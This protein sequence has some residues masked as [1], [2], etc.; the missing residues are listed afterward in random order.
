MKNFLSRVALFALAALVSCSS[1]TETSHRVQLVLSSDTL[2]PSTTFE[3][4]FDDAVAAPESVSQPAE[5][6]PLIIQPP[7]KGQFVWLSQRSGVFTPAEPTAL[8]MEYRLTLRRGLKDAGGKPLA[9]RL[10]RTL[11]TPSF[12][13]ETGW[14]GLNCSNAPATLEIKLN[15]NADVRAETARPY[16]EF[17]SRAG[18]RMS[19]HVVHGTAEDG[20][21]REAWVSSPPPATWRAQFA[22][23]VSG[24]S[25]ARDANESTN[26]VPNF[27]IVSP[28]Q[29]LPVGPGWKLVIAAGLPSAERALRLPSAHEVNLGDVIAFAPQSAETHNNVRDGRRIVLRFSKGLS[30]DIADTNLLDWIS[31]DPAPTNLTA[32]H[33]GQNTVELRGAFALHRSYAVGVRPGLESGDGMTLGRAWTNAVN[34]EP[35]PPRLY[36][37]A[38]TTEQ[39]AA[40]RREF[41]LLAVNTPSVRVRA[42]QLDRDTLIH[43][44]RGYKRYF[45]TYD[46]EYDFTE[47]Y[48]EVD[49]N[50]VAGRTIFSRTITTTN[51][52][53]NA[54][55]IPLH[56]DD[57]VGRRKSGAVFLVAEQ[58]PDERGQRVKQGTQAIVQLTDLGLAWKFT[59]DSATVHV[60]S[61]TTG[62]PVANATV[63]VL[64][65][66]SE[67]LAE[68][69]TDAQGIATLPLTTNAIWLM[70][71][72]GGDLHAARLREHPVYLYSFGVALDWSGARK[73]PCEAFLFTDRSVY[74]PGETVHFKALVRDRD[75]DRFDI[76]TGAKAVLLV[77]DP[78]D[79]KVFET[80]LT[81]SAF[82]SL[83]VSL[84]LPELVRGHYRLALRFGEREF[85]HHVQVADFQPNAFSVA[86]DTRP[87]YAAAETV[88]VPLRASYL[89]G[90]PV[91]RA[92]VAWSVE[93]SDEG[94]YPKGFEDFIFTTEW[95]DYQLGRNRSSFNDHGE[96][97]YSSKSN[98]VITPQIEFNP[99]AP[100]PRAVHLRA[101]VT[102]LNQQTITRGADF[103]AHSSDF[104]LGLRRFKEVPRAGEPLPVELIAARADGQPHTTPVTATLTLQRLDY[105]SVRVQGAGRSRGYRNELVVTNVATAEAL[106]MQLRKNLDKWDT[107]P[108]AVA[109]KLIPDQPGQY[110]LEARAKDA[111]GREVVTVTVFN[112]IGQGE[113]AWAWRN[114]VQ[115]D[116]VPD[117]TNYLAGETATVLV[118]SPFNGHALVTVEREKVLRSFV[119]E[120]SGNAP[121]IQVP[122]QDLDAPNVFVSVLLLRGSADS[123]KKFKM[124]EHRLGYCELKVT[125]PRNQLHVSVVP[126]AGDYR[127]AQTVSVTA[128][129]T[130]AIG[131]P[132]RDTEVTLYAVDEGILSL[133]GYDTPDPLSF[134][135]RP[136]PLAVRCALTLPSLFP[137]DPEQRNFH[138]KGY[139]IGGGGRDRIRKD[140]L[141]CAYWNAA[142]VT[143]AAGK[144]SATFNAP[145]SLTRYRVIAVA[146]TS[147]HQFGS[148]DSHFEVNKPLMVEPA[149]PRFAHVTDKLIARAVVHN[150]TADA[151]EIEVSLQLD[152]KANAPGNV[153]AHVF[154]KVLPV[155]AK[156]SSP[157][158]FPVEF[159][160]AGSSKWTWRAR[161]AES[162]DAVRPIVNSSS[163]RRYTDAVESTILVEYLAPM[164]REI[165]LDHTEA[166]ETNLLTAANPQLLEGRGNVAVS[167]CNSRLGELGEALRYLLHYPYGCVEQ[168]SSSLLPWITLRN[169][170]TLTPEFKKPPEE[171][172]KAIRAGVQRLLSMQT[173]SGGLS[174]WPGGREPM[175]WGSAYGGL[176]LTLARR[177]GQSVTPAKFDRLMKYLSA[178]LRGASAE[179]LDSLDSSA[180]CLALYTLALAGKAEPAYHELLF[181][182]RARLSTDNR[183]LL[184]LAIAENGGSAAMAAELLSSRTNTPRVDTDW[185]GCDS[186]DLALQLLAWTHVRPTD[187]KV[188]V[189][190]TELTHS[191]IHGHWYTTQGNAWAL[192]ALK[193]YAER[194]EGKTIATEG[195][196]TWA[197]QSRP[198]SLPAK[199]E[200][201][202]TAFPIAREAAAAPLTLA[203]PERHRLYTQ[204]TLEARPTVARQPRQ[205]RGFSIVRAYHRV[206]DDGKLQSTDTLHVGDRVLVTL[207]VDV[208]QPAHYLA[209]D[210]ALPAVL[211]PLNPEFKSQETSRAVAASSLPY[212]NWH[213]DHRE[214]RSDRAL[215]FSDH[216][217]LAGR[218]EIRYLTRVRAAGT[219][220]AP[221]AKVE[222][223]YH[224]DRFGLSETM[225]LT[226]LPLE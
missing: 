175:F 99:A 83:N 215:F 197:S 52:T 195:R 21:G 30:S 194:V 40:G 177:D 150:Q 10:R 171:F 218:Y 65:D 118:K 201:F 32:R 196:L 74:R 4:R 131:Q 86:L 112:V 45:K 24:L 206:D 108:G 184:A 3:L 20:F 58:E 6:G 101:E 35:L 14:I 222:E 219:A 134:F 25:P 187:Q 212:M 59:D 110:L 12:G 79:E 188:D 182:K 180:T 5:P 207:S 75:G 163:A 76:P 199:S 111:A 100:Q 174:Y 92:K 211:E 23:P 198:F 129:V 147:R 81:I 107:A 169:A 127:P 56:W 61:H 47:P 200:T 120:L 165:H 51:D 18:Q 57:I 216:V 19:A 50:V 33:W 138:N 78:K 77:T 105:I 90:A 160:E 208:H 26:P 226:A 190:V 73:E 130:D 85:T 17:R 68:R 143:D 102:D 1:E 223:M 146:H 103:I 71:E 148:G 122:L 104:Y 186:R 183:A 117:K 193:E 64:T 55:R 158:E 91:T 202:A 179:E 152:E 34:F 154:K 210:D 144:V 172:D 161:F 119:T 137:E 159:V 151:G 189:L 88:N 13:F 62:R 170:P 95:L 133:T 213:S 185:F 217:Y 113:T 114:E 7:L 97:A 136:R 221:C 181:K 176:V 153:K 139:L 15:F 39:L 29:P 166:G 140:F 162:D 128:E 125:N 42:K 93:A 203:N 191:R 37:P 72:S 82:G 49:Y 132:V 115:I 69:A 145:D 220:T 31:V 149:L 8:G 225:T 63:R 28:E 116:L 41:E 89:M 167:V 46:S 44:L 96:G 54:V 43:A 11:R 156:T 66:E 53:D 70:A 209:I 224:P 38:F 168:T 80:N 214:F 124:P 155:R 94:F 205:D 16:F 192:L 164:L 36:L 157:V 2:A 141:P 204:V 123:P 178:G 98:F 67:T 22:P 60:F 87:A 27:L 109:A 135:F 142:L 106:T 121:A 84:P 126:D 173:E 48:R 9:A